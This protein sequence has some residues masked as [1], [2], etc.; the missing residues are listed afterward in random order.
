[1]CAGTLKK[2][3]N[4]HFRYFNIILHQNGTHFNKNFGNNRFL[5]KPITWPLGWH[6]GKSLC[7]LQTL[8]SYFYFWLATDAIPSLPYIGFWVLSIGHHI[9]PSKPYVARS[10]TFCLII[11]I[12]VAFGSTMICTTTAFTTSTVHVNTTMFEWVIRGLL[13]TIDW[14]WFSCFM[15]EWIS[16]TVT[17]KCWTSNK[18]WFSSR[19][20][21]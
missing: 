1:M 15:F 3:K 19:Y 13:W 14:R 6:F 18:I 21:F 20:I 4:T 16:L 11:T 2:Y 17:Y 9:H 7:H 5:P 12:R 8:S 10:I